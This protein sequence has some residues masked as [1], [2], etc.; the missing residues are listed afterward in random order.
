[1]KK[2]LLTAATVTI[3]ASSSAYAMEDM[4][5]VKANAGMSK[6]NKLNGVKSKND[7]YLGVG[8][9]YYVMDNVRVDLTFDHFANPTHKTGTK[10]IKGT[11]NTLLVNGYVDLFDADLAKIFVGAGVGSGQVKAKVTDSA[12]SKANRSSK[13]RTN[14]AF[15]GYLGASYELTTGVTGELTYSYRDLGKTKKVAATA[16]TDALQSL[17]YR[18][19]HVG[20]GV[21]FDI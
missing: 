12:D 5:Y 2:I 8:A 21:R 17:H 7:V 19:H 11:A 3:L 14:L 16:T 6:L 9:G 18:G 13:Q 10:K 20:V 15:A 1:M 4:F